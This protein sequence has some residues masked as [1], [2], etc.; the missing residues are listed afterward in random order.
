MTLLKRGWI[1]LT[2]NYKNALA[3]LKAQGSSPHLFDGCDK[4]AKHI[5]RIIM[6]EDVPVN[7]MDEEKLYSFLE[8]EKAGQ[9]DYSKSVDRDGLAYVDLNKDV[10]VYPC[11]SRGCV[12][13]PLGDQQ[14]LLSSVD[15]QSMIVQLQCM[16]RL[17]LI[18]ETIQSLA[19]KDDGTML[20]TAFP[21]VGDVKACIDAGLR[22]PETF[23]AKI[24]E[25]EAMGSSEVN[26][27]FVE[28]M[29]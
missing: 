8:R 10:E 2:R 18:T 17:S 16:G 23:I 21:S 9:A 12:M 14:Y 15:V 1:L 11:V 26:F 29:E 22:L 4:E 27:D 3:G 24:N 20:Q 7:E 13:E 19:Q 6:T 28:K 25:W 5:Y